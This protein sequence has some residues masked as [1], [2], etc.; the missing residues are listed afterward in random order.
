M[1]ISIS[2]T[3]YESRWRRLIILSLSLMPTACGCF[4]I[5]AY[6][7]PSD[8]DHTYELPEVTVKSKNHKYLHIL[9]YLREY[10]SLFNST[11]TVF[12]YRE[13]IVDFLLPTSKT[14]KSRGW[15]APRLLASRSYF[16]FTDSDGLDSVSDYFSTHFSLSDWIGLPGNFSLPVKLRDA[17]SVNDTVMGRYRPVMIW[18]KTEENV[19]FIIDV[20]AAQAP[21]VRIPGLSSLMSRNPDC[22]NLLINYKFENVYYDT[23]IAS[24]FSGM[25]FH[26]GPCG[27]GDSMRRIFH[28]EEPSYAETYAELYIAGREYMTESEA[29]RCTKKPPQKDQLSFTP[30][31]EAPE[32]HAY[33]RRLISRV[34]AIDHADIRRKEKPDER[35]AGIEDLT[36]KY[37]LI[38]WLKSLI[39]LGPGTKE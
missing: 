24:N 17:E 11:D 28:T 13:K 32:L 6:N 29:R 5:S 25:T 8:N 36:K 10:S 38:G 34:E 27:K 4:A 35:Y 26:V 20:M 37:T 15:T 16:Q 3:S 12:L 18:Q 14:G 2:D 39:G 21:P 31:P 1:N 9:G 7:Q 30:P 22:D 19:S 33:I 23:I